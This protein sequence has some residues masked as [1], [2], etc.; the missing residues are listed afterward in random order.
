MNT[1]GEYLKVVEDDSHYLTL[2]CVKS[3]LVLLGQ[4]VTTIREMG[5]KDAVNVRYKRAVESGMIVGPRTFTCAQSI[6]ATGGTGHLTSR[7]ADGPDEFRRAAREQLFAGADLV[8]V[9]ASHTGMTRAGYSYIAQLT[10]DEMRAA[11]DVAHRAGKPTASHALDATSI[12][13]SLEAGA[14][15]IEHGH[16]L[17][18]ETCRRMAANGTFLVCTMTGHWQNAFNAAQWGRTARGSATWPRH[19]ESYKVALEHGVKIATGCDGVGNVHQEMAL[20]VEGGMRPMDALVA[21]TRRGAEL[22]EIDHKTGTIEAGKW[23]DLIVLDG[24][25]LAD[26][27]NTRS[28]STVWSRGVAYPVPTIQS[29]TGAIMA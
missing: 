22:L 18:A 25:P 3:G 23:A 20:M 5:A 24:D 17:D 14:D 8:K 1:F 4:G 26:I 7:A 28:V 13:D 19:F 29:M 27:A 15:S 12:C 21:A 16:E 9:K 10:V 2:R 6:I 11:F